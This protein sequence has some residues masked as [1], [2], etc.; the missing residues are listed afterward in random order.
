MNL[1]FILKWHYTED[2]LPDVIDSEYADVFFKLSTGDVLVGIFTDG[3]FITADSHSYDIEDVKRW[4]YTIHID[5]KEYPEDGAI[6]A[7]EHPNYECLV[8]GI[9]MD[10]YF[11]EGMDERDEPLYEVV[12]VYANTPDETSVPFSEVTDWYNFPTR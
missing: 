9:Y 11:P 4:K 5:E 1:N 7:I 6:I 3:K 10:E 8:E 2:L 12:V